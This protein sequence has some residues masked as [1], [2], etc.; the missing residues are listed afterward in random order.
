MG[1][2]PESLPSWSGA[3]TAP[4][5]V[6]K[7]TWQCA[8]VTPLPPSLGTTGHNKHTVEQGTALCALSAGS[9]DRSSVWSPDLRWW[10]CCD[11][12]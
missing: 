3:R 2:G 1:L 6:Q 5:R 9:G 12:D 10:T 4:W 7:G 11:S 8:C